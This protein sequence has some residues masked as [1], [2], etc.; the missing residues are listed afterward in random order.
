[1]GRGTNRLSTR[2]PDRCDQGTMPLLVARR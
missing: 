2:T 1:V